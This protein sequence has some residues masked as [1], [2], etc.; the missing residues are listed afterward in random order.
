LVKGKGFICLRYYRKGF[1]GETG[2]RERETETE[3]QRQRE[4]EEKMEKGKKGRSVHDIMNPRTGSVLT[5]GPRREGGKREEDGK[6]GAEVEIQNPHIDRESDDVL[7]HLGLSNIHY[8][9]EE[10]FGDVRFVCMGGS[11]A[12]M[13]SF[14]KYFLDRSGAKLPLGCGLVP[15]GKT[16]RYSMFKVG[17]VIS[18]NHGMGMASMSILLH[19]IQKL[20]YHARAKNVTMFRIGTS[21]G[22]GVEAGTVVVAKEAVNPIDFEPYFSQ[23]TMDKVI[24]YP[25]HFN[26]ELVGKVL[27]CAEASE[28]GKLPKLSAITGKTMATDDFYEG[29][30]RL[31]GALC[32]YNEEDKLAWITR[33][34]K[35]GVRNIEMEGS[36]FGAF[37]NRSGIPGVLCNTVLLNRLAG[38]QVTSSP[39]ELAQFSLNSQELV[40]RYILTVIN[41]K[42][43]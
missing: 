22:L 21:G 1:E 23:V 42:V 28:D 43:M 15:I 3:R 13:E 30:G 29:Q 18:V 2:K 20:L 7:Y 32:T 31:D 25:S 35:A 10:M 14:A 34:H 40:V 11:A 5:L 36:L 12:R 27:Q 6:S 38:D 4:K 19:E 39:A 37:C 26:E 8:D 17:P 16:E 24:K 41:S 33:A 9:L